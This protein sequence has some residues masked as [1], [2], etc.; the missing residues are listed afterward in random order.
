MQCAI[1]GVGGETRVHVA[2]SSF[3][4]WPVLKGDLPLRVQ[5]SHDNSL[6]GRHF[7]FFGQQA[8]PIIAL[9]RNIPNIL[10][11]GFVYHRIPDQKRQKAS[12]GKYMKQD[13]PP[14]RG[15]ER[16]LAHCCCSQKN[17]MCACDKV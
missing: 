5:V 17:R 10:A 11:A 1:F 12:T 13:T 16:E 7:L 6:P 15:L 2:E 4:A 3:D 9:D 14:Q 8:G